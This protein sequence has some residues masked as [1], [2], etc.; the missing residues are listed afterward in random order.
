MQKRVKRK[1]VRYNRPEVAGIFYHENMTY[2]H[3]A[4]SLDGKVILMYRAPC[5]VEVP[6]VSAQNEKDIRDEFKKS[7]CRSWD[8]SGGAGTR[9]SC[10]N[11]SVLCTVHA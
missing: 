11:K 10:G 2:Y 7:R 5:R 6:C 3:N 4:C 9:Q 8:Y 1:E